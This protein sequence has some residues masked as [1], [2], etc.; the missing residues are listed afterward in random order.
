MRLANGIFVD[1]EATFGELRFSAL[2][3]EEVEYDGE[4]NATKKVLSRR[5]DLK[6]KGQK[7]MI[8]VKIPESA[9]EKKFDYNA[10]VE[11][12]NPILGTVPRTEGRLVE[13][14]WYIKAD[15]IVLK[16]QTRRTQNIPDT[17]KS[18]E[19]NNK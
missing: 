12:V 7:Q 11:L 6:S 14:E 18:E 13:A 3:S 5:Y 16:G 2:R 10:N 9:G 8:Q 4:G 15:D 17:H 19:K 1:N